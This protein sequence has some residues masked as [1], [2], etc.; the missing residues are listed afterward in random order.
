MGSDLQGQGWGQGTGTARGE[1]L[2]SQKHTPGP[3]KQRGASARALWPAAMVLGRWGVGDRE[4]GLEGR[5][6]ESIHL[7]REQVGD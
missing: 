4:A 1:T 5:D 6:D 2:M 3:G 7:V